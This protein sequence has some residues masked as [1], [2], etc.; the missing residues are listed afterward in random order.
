MKA[1]Q[2][3]I[4]RPFQPQAELRPQIARQ[5]S[6]TPAGTLEHADRI[7][8]FPERAGKLERFRGILHSLDAGPVRNRETEYFKRRVVRR[9]M[10]VRLA[11]SDPAFDLPQSFRRSGA[12]VE[13]GRKH[14]WRDT[15]VTSNES[16]ANT[17]LARFVH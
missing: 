12:Q 14:A 16:N 1:F 15:I 17:F 10:Q 11:A 2:I 5:R 13:H 8:I 7:E 6:D 3:G 9:R 4:E